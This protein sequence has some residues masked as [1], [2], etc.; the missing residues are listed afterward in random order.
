M[1]RKSKQ[2]LKLEHKK[3]IECA[4]AK[5]Y[6]EKQK[7]QGKVRLVKWITQDQKQFLEEFIFP[8]I[9]KLTEKWKSR[10]HDL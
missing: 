2:Q 4:K 3:A 6:Y 9:D 8:D 10:K 7:Q 1:G 5:R